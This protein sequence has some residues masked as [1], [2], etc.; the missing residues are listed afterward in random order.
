MALRTRDEN[1][2]APPAEGYPFVPVQPSSSPRAADTKPRRQSARAAMGARTHRHRHATRPWRLLLLPPVALAVHGWPGGVWWMLLAILGLG[3][4]VGVAQWFRQKRAVFR[5]YALT[6]ILAATLWSMWT[7]QFGLWGDP[8]RYSP[9][10]FLVTW[11]LLAWPWWERHRTRLTDDKPQPERVTHP[12]V[13]RW[14]NEIGCKGGPLAESSLHRPEDV[15]SGAA[16][17]LQLLRGQTIEDAEQA[18]RKIASMLGISRKRI[19][20]EPLPGDGPGDSED[21]SLIRMILAEAQSPH[22]EKRPWQGPSLDRATGTYSHS[23]YPDGSDARARL[24]R[25]ENGIAI[26]AVN[27]L[28]S[29]A[30]GSGKSRGAAL[31]ALE[32]LA[33]GFTVLWFCDGQGG[34]SIP[35]LNEYADWSAYTRD[36]T[37]RL[38]CAAYRVMIARARKQKKR[39][40]KDSRGHN[41]IGLG[42]WRATPADP[43]LLLLVDEA[44]EVLR[45]PLAVRLIKAIL[46]MGNKVGIGVDLIT[47]VPLLNELGGESGDGGA[48]VVRAMAKAGNVMVYRAE[49]A[50]T[51]MI[52]LTNGMSVNPQELPPGGGMLYLAGATVR[53]MHS[54]THGV[55]EDDLY[56]WLSQLDMAPL[57]EFSARAAGEDYATRRQRAADA[58]VAVDELDIEELDN[59]LA[60]LLGERLPGQEKPGAV[61][62]K[63]TINEAVFNAL[64]ASG[65]PMKREE[66]I[67]AVVAQGKTASESSI[68]KALTWWRNH[69]HIE[70]VDG[71]HGYYDLVT[72]EGQDESVLA[73]AA[74]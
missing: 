19:L 74:T 41:R 45:N 42:H 55:A 34:V 24:Y 72:R 68:A 30:V 2:T 39:K 53:P 46:R 29:G 40:W 63:M 50:T 20:F 51:G 60:I 10:M 18:K 62:D 6:C 12:M 21:E 66:I 49:D 23:V 26:R 4:L 64:K 27:S 56:H 16:F 36:E 52:A 38:L 17:R 13:E 57:D 32:H 48:Q 43:F 15:L 67:T 1:P 7:V 28:F 71:R 9:V 65:G 11:V 70:A 33:T 73:G 61:A 3:V 44:H 31:K 25:A 5:A 47:Q 58:E 8:G 35:E 37:M 54:C 14:A 69:G 59:E 22:N